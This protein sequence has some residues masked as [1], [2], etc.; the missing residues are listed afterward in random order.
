MMI[1]K[2]WMART[3]TRTAARR[4][5]YPNHPIPPLRLGASALAAVLCHSAAA[6]SPIDD[7]LTTLPGLNSTQTNM[8]DVIEEACPGPPNVNDPAFQARCNAVL[9]A[10]ALGNDQAGAVNA[11]QQVGPDQIISQGTEATKTSSNVLGVRL[12][13]LRAGATG[14]SLAGLNPNGQALSN[15]ALGRLYPASGGA[16]GDEESAAW[17]R[18]G[19]FVNGLGQFG[20]VDSTFNQVGF[21]FDR[22]GVTA[23]ADYRFTK[24]SVLG[25]AFSYVRTESGFDRDGGDLDSDSYTGSLYGTVYAA[26]AFYIDGIASFGGINYDSTRRISY[27]AGVDVVNTEAK[28]EPDGMQYSVSLGGG[29]NVSLGEV[30]IDPYARINYTKLDLDGFSES[31]GSGWAMQFA[32]QRV[33]SVTTALGTQVSYAVSAPFGVLLPYVRGEWHHEYEDDSRNISVRFLGDNRSGL[34]FNTLTEGPDRNY[35]TVGTGISGTFAQGITA[36]LNYDALLGYHSIESHAFLV[37]ARM[38]F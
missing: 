4:T 6:Q 1:S 17:N 13:A 2:L 8:A 35:F 33:E 10:A 22:G 38:E 21:D 31:G 19:V 32:D 27:T 3:R 25:A 11:L 23:G 12:T 9:G 5:L 18:L 26:D 7:P 29:Y 28:A 24:N 30:T 34:T 36:F 20:S 16:A 37:G 15:Q 14:L